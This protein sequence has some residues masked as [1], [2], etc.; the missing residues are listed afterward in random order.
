[1][2]WLY[3]RRRGRGPESHT[4][5]CHEHWFIR[6]LRDARNTACCD[7]IGCN[8]PRPLTHAAVVA[9]FNEGHPT[10]QAHVV[11]DEQLRMH[12]VSNA[13]T[14][15]LKRRTSAGPGGAGARV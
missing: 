8:S 7:P 13:L 1:M 12:G 14:V 11:N 15:L 10:V 6:G 3:R 5:S 9:V 2:L 4:Q